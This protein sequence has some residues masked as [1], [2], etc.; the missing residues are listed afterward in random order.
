MLQ[1]LWTDMPPRIQISSRG[2]FRFVGPSIAISIFSPSTTRRDEAPLEDIEAQENTQTSSTTYPSRKPCWATWIRSRAGRRPRRWVQSLSR[3]LLHF[4]DL[5]VTVDLA[6]GSDVQVTL[7]AGED[8][9]QEHHAFEP[10]TSGLVIGGADSRDNAA[11]EC[12]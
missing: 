11:G 5:T 2:V 4:P 8:E 1:A 12:S 7:L 6:G 10:S 3:L 9:D